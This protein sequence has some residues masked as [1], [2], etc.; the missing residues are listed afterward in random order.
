MEANNPNFVPN[1]ST[2]PPHRHSHRLSLLLV[3]LSLAGGILF[4]QL[5]FQQQTGLNL[6]LFN[7]FI[8]SVLIF[9][10]KIPVRKYPLWLVLAVTLLSAVT[11][12]WHNSQ[13][14]IRLNLV[15]LFLLSSLAY[16]PELKSLKNVFLASGEKVLTFFRVFGNIKTD[17]S[18]SKGAGKT[19]RIIRIVFIPLIII[20][21][22]VLIYYH[23]NPYFAKGFDSFAWW[24]QPLWSRLIK[25]FGSLPGIWSFI[26][27]SVLCIMLFF[28][29]PFS[30]L[31][32][33]DAGETD[34]LVRFRKNTFKMF[35]PLIPGLKREYLSSLI[36]M[37]V[38]NILILILNLTD[39]FNVWL[40]FE[41]DG[42]TLKQFVHEGTWLLVI[43][44]FIS[45]SIALYIFRGNLNFF[46]KN[47]TLSLLTRIWIY[48]NLFM[49]LSV[50]IRNYWYFHYFNLAY[51]RIGVF[52]FLLAVVIG[53]ISIILKIRKRHTASWL[54]KTNS[55]SV[56][57]ILAF[58]CLFN[59]DG[60]IA[61][62]NFKRAHKAYLHRDFLITM[63]SSVLPVLWKNKNLLD[64]PLHK[65]NE[66]L[67]YVYKEFENVY[68][69]DNYLQLL[70]SKT[71][72]FMEQMEKRNW[73]E[74]NYADYRAWEMLQKIKTE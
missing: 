31:A 44:I 14:S 54:W 1:A 67:V 40:F 32:R 35:Q 46:S 34:F 49:T 19:L 8:I 23:A 22:F 30:V 59:W 20:I 9:A 5:F 11:A 4:Q 48:Q 39:L 26:W 16:Y 29:L 45:M 33:T 41:W 73:L 47:K 13:I 60:I 25:W 10:I 70:E 28:P 72:D 18:I 64:A 37:S 71:N 24:I 3:F 7:V 62:T 55:L 58:I 56:Y 42:Q 57:L 15:S 53:L 2:P 61:S 68:E 52:F 51:L 50:G 36:L 43:S 12:V 63:P 69:N 74:W 66:P 6:L 17:F 21:L 27:G 38:L 65:D